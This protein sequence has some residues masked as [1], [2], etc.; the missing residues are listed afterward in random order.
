MVHRGTAESGRFA[1]AWDGVLA[2]GDVTA[3]G[4]YLLRLEVDSDQGKEALQRVIAL[5][6]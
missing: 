1:L 2:N 6:Y 4:L 3:P 5:A